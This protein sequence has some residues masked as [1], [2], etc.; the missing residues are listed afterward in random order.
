MVWDPGKCRPAKSNVSL[1]LAKFQWETEVLYRLKGDGTYVR[2]S[3]S[4]TWKVTG[5]ARK[6]LSE[7]WAAEHISFL[8][9]KVAVANRTKTQL[10]SSGASRATITATFSQK[11]RRNRY[12]KSSAAIVYSRPSG[13]AAL[14]LLTTL[15]ITQ[16]FIKIWLSKVNADRYTCRPIFSLSATHTISDNNKM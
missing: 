4:T 7:K 15:E 11:Y 9:L 3:I 5:L 1:W 6:P 14:Q 13:S 12:C 16:E 10:K 8:F 2:K